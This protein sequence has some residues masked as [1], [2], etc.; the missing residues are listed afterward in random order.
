MNYAAQGL[1]A[2]S[3]LVLTPVLLHH[4]GRTTYGLWVVAGGAVAYLEL[5][6]LGFGGATTKLIAEDA[7]VRP[8]QAVRTLNTTFFVLVPLGLIALVAGVGLAFAL[9]HIVHVTESLRTSFVVWWPCSP[10]LSPSRSRETRSVAP[11][12]AISATTC[13]RPRTPR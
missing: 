3:A 4:L 9:P 6:E 5:F 2:L 7:S 13:W 12:W 8:E 10:W 1:T 11:W